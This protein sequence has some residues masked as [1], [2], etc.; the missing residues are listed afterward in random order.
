MDTIF[1]C[2]LMILFLFPCNFDI[3]KSTGDL[4]DEISNRLK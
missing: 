4:N 2:R 3:L 1:A